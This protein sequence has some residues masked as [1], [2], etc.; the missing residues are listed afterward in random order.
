MAQVRIS[1]IVASSQATL[2]PGTGTLSITGVSVFAGGASFTGTGNTTVTDGA[3]VR[4]G[5]ISATAVQTNA[6]VRIA[7]ISA[8][9]L[10]TSAAH[11]RVMS[12]LAFAVKNIWRWNGAAWVNNISLDPSYN[13]VGSL[14]VSNTPAWAGSI[15]TSGAGTLSVYG[16]PAG[17]SFPILGGVGQLIITGLISLSGPALFAGVGGFNDSALINIILNPNTVDSVEFLYTPPLWRNVQFIMGSLRYSIPTSYCVYKKNGIWYAVQS[18]SVGELTGADPVYY[19][20]TIVNSAT[21]T[22][23]AAFGQGTLTEVSNQP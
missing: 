9:S 4:I 18:V 1:D 14:F 20:P 2:F 11:V 13:G 12:E 5:S 10:N 19:T 6:Q 7:S 8:T 16:L 3:R 23:L 21:A 15:S 17:P 22:E